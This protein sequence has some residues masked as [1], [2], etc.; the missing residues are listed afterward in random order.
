MKGASWLVLPNSVGSLSPP[1]MS[2]VFRVIANFTIVLGVS[3]PLFN[4]YTYIK[5]TEKA[6]EKLINWNYESNRRLASLLFTHLSVRLA[7]NVRNKAG[8]HVGAIFFFFFNLVMNR[9]AEII[10]KIDRWMDR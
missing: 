10:K 4:T 7:G 8:K 2:R 3:L 1:E 6:L 5:G 9:N